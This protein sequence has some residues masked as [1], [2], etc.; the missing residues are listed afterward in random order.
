MDFGLDKLIEMIEE[1][2]GKTASTAVLFAVMGGAFAW[3]VH[4]F[5]EFLVVP[6]ATYGFAALH[7]V[8]MAP[9][10]R[11]QMTLALLA[12][13]AAISITTIGAAVAYIAL[14]PYDPEP[15]S[16]L[17]KLIPIRKRGLFWLVIAVVLGGVSGSIVN[18]ER[19][20]LLR[21]IAV[22]LGDSRPDLIEMQSAAH[23]MRDAL[24]M[25]C[26]EL[27]TNLPDE[28]RLVLEQQRT[29]KGK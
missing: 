20:F 11:A 27:T 4:A 26:R 7:Y 15:K 17:F 23:K 8:Q 19:D 3:G 25:A 9:T 18:G 29:P 1:R 5:F 22:T 12:L 21:D 28:C 24:A 14:V 2:F 10:S 13:A 16:A 6:T